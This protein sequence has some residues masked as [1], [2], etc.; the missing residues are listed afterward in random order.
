MAD[1]QAPTPRMPDPAALQEAWQDIAARSQR[2]LQDFTEKQA[3]DGGVGASGDVLNLTGTFLDFTA[4]LMADPQRVV[5]AQMELWQQY[6]QL[7]QA[8]AD[9]MMGKPAAPKPVA[10]PVVKAAA[11]A[12]PKPAGKPA[13]KVPAAK[14]PV[15]P[16]AVASPAAKAAAVAN[17]LIPFV[18]RGCGLIKA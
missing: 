2:L 9:R 17:D 7:W 1:T 18:L 13:A 8:T 11:K 16:K 15:A 14:A 6:M 5:T 4:K 12:A 10:K 3:K